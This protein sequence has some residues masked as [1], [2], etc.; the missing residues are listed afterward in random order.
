MPC[1][2]I[3]QQSWSGAILGHF[4]VDPE[5]MAYIDAEPIFNKLFSIIE[6]MTERS[7]L[8]RYALCHGR[9]MYQP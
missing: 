1:Q 9:R 2:E 3:A 5:M 7:R 8:A 4:T 6:H